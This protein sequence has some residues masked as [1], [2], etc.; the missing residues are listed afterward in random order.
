MS[1]PLDSVPGC[2]PESRIPV[3]AERIVC[4]HAVHDLRG[5]PVEELRYPA[6]AAL[7]FAGVPGAGKSTALHRYFGVRPEDE[8][9][10]RGPAGLLVLDSHHAR[11]RWKRRLGWLPYPLWRPL[12]HVVHYAGIRSA[13]R[14][15][16]GPVVIHECATFRWTRAMIAR[17]A[18]RFQRELHVVLLDVP[19][20]EAMAGQRARG[21]RVNG[22][23]FRLHVRRWREL[24]GTVSEVAPNPVPCASVVVVDRPTV[25]AIARVTFAD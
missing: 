2:A 15:V 14:T 5:R 6:H 17:W 1:P 8:S 19:A 22:V 11:N 7:V 16:H 21:R 25:N 9:P 10:P 18:R 13:L 3:A 24:L 23:S 4:P 12:V 20:T